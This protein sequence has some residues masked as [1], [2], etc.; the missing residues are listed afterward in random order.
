MLIKHLHQ[1]RYQAKAGFLMVFLFFDGYFHMDG[2]AYKYGGYESQ[3]I[4][5]VGHGHLINKLGCKTN[6][7]RKYERSVSDA[8]FEWLCFTPFFVHM[9]RKK[10]ARLPGMEYNIGFSDGAAFS[11]PD[12]IR[13]EFFKV[14]LY[15]HDIQ[16]LGCL[17]NNVEFLQC[18]KLV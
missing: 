18:I 17:I 6:S 15:K 13:L 3:A 14:F 2:V 12:F 1:F 10:I 5:P 7:H 16:A 8:L 4:V 11:F 9:M